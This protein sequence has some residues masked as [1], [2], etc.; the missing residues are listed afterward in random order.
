MRPVFGSTA[1]LAGT[2][3]LRLPAEAQIGGVGVAIER[4]AEVV[5]GRPVPEVDG[6][7]ACRARRAESLVDRR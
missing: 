5:E 1:T 2:G 7:A 6:S 4:G 3:G